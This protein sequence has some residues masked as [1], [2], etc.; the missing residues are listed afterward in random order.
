MSWKIGLVGT[1]NVAAFWAINLTK[2]TGASLYV[3]GSNSGSLLESFNGV[4]VNNRYVFASAGELI[5]VYSAKTHRL[6]KVF[7]AHLDEVT[8]LDISSDGKYLISN[9]SFSFFSLSFD[10]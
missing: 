1:G 7:K 4:A 9:G 2:A 6:I 8:K 10:L 5:N 3:K